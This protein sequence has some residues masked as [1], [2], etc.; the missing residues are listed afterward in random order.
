[1]FLKKKAKKTK[2][3]FFEQKTDIKGMELTAANLK[4]VL[5]GSKD[6]VFR[7]LEINAL[8]RIPVT[9]IYIDGLVDSNG[10]A[11]F[12][13]KPLAENRVFS[14][15]RS[16]EEAIRE[17]DKGAV[18]YPAQNTRNQLGEV[19]DDILNGATA[20]VFDSEKKALVFDAKN[21]AKRGV[22]PP[23][24]ESS[25][26]GPKDCFVETFR[27]NTSIVR[28]KI[29]TPNL[30]I[31]EVTIGKQTRT[32][33]GIFYIK[34][35]AS[36]KIVNEVKK[37]LNSISIDGLIFM[38]N[39]EE[40]FIDS[41]YTPF[42][43][44]SFTEKPDK[45]CSELVEG[46]VGMIVDGYPFSMVVPMT[47]V[48]TLQIMDDYNFNFFM[49]SGYRILRWVLYFIT[50]FLPGFYVAVTTFHQEMIPTRLVLSIAESKAGTPFPI[51][52][53]V[54]LAIAAFNIL[55]QAG[56]GVWKTIGNTVSI[57]G[58][59]VLGEAAITASLISPGVVIVV[60]VAA[61]AT[62]AIPSFELTTAAMIWQ[63]IITVFC[64]FFGLY[65]LILASLLLL[66]NL[67]TI[68]VLGVPY[69]SPLVS[70]EGKDMQDSLF[71]LPVRTMKKR[72]GYLKTENQK[73]Q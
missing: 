21:F 65:G 24:E 72:P 50:L 25:L 35:I 37:R 17:I 27:D 42:P 28:R 5:G 68:E 32:T 26:K 47:F 39:L 31:D 1:M 16:A 62:L 15:I 6:I 49:A 56:V 69:L 48:D 41:K 54:L 60:A 51:F 43:Q 12:I 52:I 59:L 2:E 30:M 14:Q 18:Y 55:L 53:E 40:H 45:F 4:T 22:T 67:C 61:I 71:R 10:I 63:L 7:S 20:L 8:N 29:K 34:G 13:L 46:R 11:D 19:I 33:V 23:V 70:S 58:A 57:V 36:Q 3:I 38:A 66:Y 44:I 9:L 64:S 73:K